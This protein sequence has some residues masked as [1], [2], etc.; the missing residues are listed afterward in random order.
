MFAA[1]NRPISMSINIDNHRR[2]VKTE[3]TK[4]QGALFCY[5]AGGANGSSPGDGFGV[6]TAAGPLTDSYGGLMKSWP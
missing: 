3:R 4:G 6:R 5:C 1:P 2:S